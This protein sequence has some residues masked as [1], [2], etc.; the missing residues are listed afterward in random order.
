MAYL[1]SSMKGAWRR[2]HINLALIFV[3]LAQIYLGCCL[4]LLVHSNV[5]LT[6]L[7]GIRLSG[8]RRHSNSEIFPLLWDRCTRRR[9][10][11]RNGSS[12]DDF[13]LRVVIPSIWLHLCVECKRLRHILRENPQIV[14]RI[15][16]KVAE[17]CPIPPHFL[18]CCLN[19]HRLSASH[20]HVRGEGPW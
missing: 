4:V 20:H 9:R 3:K 17:I 10:W 5:S 13:E 15:L 6:H 7:I 14:S 18:Q 11:R 12:L 19:C 16:L 8:H 2:R 1:Y